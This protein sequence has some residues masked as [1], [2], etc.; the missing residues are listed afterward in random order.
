MGWVAEMRR[1]GE[2][3]EEQVPP[4]WFDPNIPPG[5]DVVLLKPGSLP[6]GQR[7]ETVEDAEERS[8]G[9]EKDIRQ[10]SRRGHGALAETL[11]DCRANQH[12][13]LDLGKVAAGEPVGNQDAKFGYRNDQKGKLEFLFS[14]QQFEEIVGGKAPANTV[15]PDLDSRGLI[16]TT[17]AGKQKKKYVVRRYL[18][19]ENKERSWVVAIDAKILEVDE[20]G[21]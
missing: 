8:R 3:P 9:L 6:K 21:S 5:V 10:H 2:K 18:N 12:R 15:K 14:E 11:A 7:F 13:F 20:P 19:P 16:V 17:G 1:S 4:Y